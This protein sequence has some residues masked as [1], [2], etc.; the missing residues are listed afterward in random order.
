MSAPYL[1][2]PTAR[3]PLVSL[4]ASLHAPLL[5]LLLVLLT[6][7]CGDATEAGVGGEGTGG[8]GVVGRVDGFGSTIVEGERLDD[9][10][11]RVIVDGGAE[12]PLTAVKLGTQ[13]QVQADAGR[14]L[15]ASVEAEIVGPIDADAPDAGPFTVLGQRVIFDGHPVL[16]PVVDGIVDLLAG[17]MVE[18]HGLRLANGDV[19]A[20]R[21][22]ARSPALDALRLRGEVSQLDVAARRLRIGAQAVS[23]AGATIEPAG[24]TLV[25][26]AQ[27]TVLASRRLQSGSVLTAQRVVIAAPLADGAVRVAGFATQVRGS[28]LRLRGLRVEAAAARLVNGTA[29]DLRNDSVVR[30]RGRIRAGT[31]HAD[32]IAFVRNAADLPIDVTGPVTDFS[33]S[34]SAFRLR[35]ANMRLSA[36]TQLTG[37]SLDN[38]GNGVLLRVRGRIEAGEVV[39]TQLDWITPS[40]VAAGTVTGYNAATATLRLPPLATPVRIAAGAVL[41]GGSAAD[42]ADGRRL[43]VAGTAGASEFVATEVSFLDALNAP[44]T[45]LLTG[46]SSD[47]QSGRVFVN[48]TPVALA[49]QTVIVGGPTGSALDLDGG[50][51]LI[52]RAQR[53]GGVLTAQR[54]EIRATLDDDLSNALG[55]VTQFAGPADLRVAGQRVDARGATFTGGTAAELR[56][57]AFVLV[58]G[59]MRDGVLIARRIEFLPN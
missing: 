42:L 35:G 57:T 50:Q 45:V 17:T 18:V 8:F 46:L 4:L 39:A 43:R 55:Y 49:P 58:E 21:V 36:A 52:V 56:D 41:R 38:L 9:R 27:V 16:R 59:T 7:A 26:G 33:G 31:L 37:G 3:R 22:Q 11:A 34:D 20:T 53:I 29:A 14:L 23:Y 51:Y 2:S 30:V 24:A 1:P 44:A 28:T 10:D 54:I 47:V 19:V 48:D 32:E 40:P 15:R 5:A 6:A 25:D 13:V 12:A